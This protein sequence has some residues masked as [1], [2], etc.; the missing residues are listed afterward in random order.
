[1]SM[2]RTVRMN[3]DVSDYVA[4][5]V[6]EAVA[7]GAFESESELVD[8]AL[9]HWLIARK[10]GTISEAELQASLERGVREPGIDAEVV[11]E[12]LEKKYLAMAEVQESR[13][14]GFKA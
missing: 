14:R 11:L 5:G 1:M 8:E 12:R 3:T 4:R 10:M 13:P 2:R 7:S 9:H 6:K